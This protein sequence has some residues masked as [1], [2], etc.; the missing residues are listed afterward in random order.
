[1]AIPRGNSRPLSVAAS[2]PV[3]CRTNRRS[4]VKLVSPN[5]IAADSS[6]MYV[7]RAWVGIAKKTTGSILASPPPS[8]P[9]A[10]RAKHIPKQSPAAI[11]RN[12]TSC[13]PR[14]GD[15]TRNKATPIRQYRFGIRYSVRSVHATATNNGTINHR[16][17]Q[18]CQGRS[19]IMRVPDCVCRAR[20]RVLRSKPAV[21]PTCGSSPFLS[22][23]RYA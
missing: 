20:L 9:A 19:I 23:R 22:C 3:G 21:W 15:P 8:Q 5:A 7:E 4:R 14:A 16:G 6:S 13:K 12:P 10:K 18:L 17:A 1:M 2:F 11:N